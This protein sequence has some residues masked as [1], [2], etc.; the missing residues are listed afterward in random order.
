MA[1]EAI[2]KA[3]LMEPTADHGQRD[4]LFTYKP[5]IAQLETLT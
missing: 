2:D 5:K 4:Q 1:R 3:W